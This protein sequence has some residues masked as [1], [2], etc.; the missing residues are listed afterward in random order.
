MHVE[1]CLIF[2]VTPGTKCDSKLFQSK[3]QSLIYIRVYYNA[4]VSSEE[5]SEKKLEKLTGRALA[6]END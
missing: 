5:Q 2:S 6:E 3:L 4:F 1:S